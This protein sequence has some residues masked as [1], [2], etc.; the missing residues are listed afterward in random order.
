MKA[1]LIVYEFVNGVTIE[2]SLAVFAD[3]R[4]CESV[5]L[6]FTT[7]KNE[8]NTYGAMFDYVCKSF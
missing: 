1:L 4:D 3:I 2:R 7:F 8:Y 6:I 5:G